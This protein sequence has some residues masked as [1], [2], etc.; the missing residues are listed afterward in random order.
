VPTVDVVVETKQSNSVR[1]KQLSAM[2]DVPLQETQRLEWSGT[3]PIEER[4]WSVG[5]IVGPSGSGK[6]TVARRLFPEQL[7]HDIAWPDG[8]VIDGFPAERSVVEI[9]NICQ[10]V[11]FNTIPAWMRPHHVLSN[12]E[13]FR[14]DM[15]RLLADNAPLCVVDEFTSL[16]DRRV[17]KL[18]AHAVQKHIRKTQR[19]FVAVTCHEDVEDWLQPDWVL[20]PAT[21]NFRWRSLQRHPPIAISIQRVPRKLWR[22]FAPFHYLTADMH[23]SAACYALYADGALASF[24]GVLY[25]PHATVRNVYGLSRLVTLPDFQGFGFAMILSATLG[26]AFKSLNQ[27]FRTY[28]AHP[29]LIRSFDRHQDWSLKKQPGDWSHK[30]KTN[31]FRFGGRPNATFEYV[32]PATIDV[33]TA[34]QLLGIAALNGIKQSV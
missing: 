11:G 2:F 20:E 16:V 18:T 12:G 10:S 29:A 32:G 27:R 6:S 9:S 34:K 30:T 25:R 7:T 4:A 23:T 26:N 24:A 14:A 3:V 15:A 19:Q 33:N 1:A 17:A 28:P 13:K 22:V 5:L 8:A 31:A 21:M